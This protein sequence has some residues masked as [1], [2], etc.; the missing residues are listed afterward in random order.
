[1]LLAR[2]RPIVLISIVGGS[3]LLVDAATASTLWHSDAGSGS[4]PPHL[5]W[6]TWDKLL[7]GGDRVGADGC[8]SS[9]HLTVSF[10]EKGLLG[11]GP[12]VHRSREAPDPCR[13]REFRP[14]GR[15]RRRSNRPGNSQAKG[16]RRGLDTL[17]SG[18]PQCRP[19]EGVSARRQAL[20]HALRFPDRGGAGGRCP[21][22]ALPACRES[23]Q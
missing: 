8:K 22:W 16:P 11:H 15:N 1:M 3:F 21:L 7:V 6:L 12:L 9:K 20:A 4:H 19:T 5:L 18:R 23:P 17:E 14:F 13:G 2:S 10:G